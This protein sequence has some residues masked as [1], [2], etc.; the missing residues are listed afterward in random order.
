MKHD[1]HLGFYEA[2]GCGSLLPFLDQ[3]GGENLP[4]CVKTSHS[5]DDV[6]GET[7]GLDHTDVIIRN[8]AANLVKLILSDERLLVFQ[9]CRCLAA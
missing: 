7:T 5:A 8:V 2:V 3:F 9:E 6:R 4:V 1:Q